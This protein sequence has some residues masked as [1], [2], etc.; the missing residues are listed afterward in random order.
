MCWEDVRQCL[1][2]WSVKF[3]YRYFPG[4]PFS[5]QIMGFLIKLA[6]LNMYNQWLKFFSSTILQLDKISAEAS[7]IK[8]IQELELGSWRQ[9][10]NIP[11]NRLT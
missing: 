8:E 2:H 11:V 7:L 1:G 5:Y 10:F 3:V 9:Q 6:Q 4:G